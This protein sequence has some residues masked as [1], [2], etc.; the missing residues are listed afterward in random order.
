[1]KNGPLFPGLGVS[2][3]LCF[4]VCEIPCPWVCKSQSQLLSI[5]VN[6]HHILSRQETRGAKVEGLTGPPV[7]IVD[8][9]VL[10]SE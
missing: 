6:L 5:A 4:S 3:A 1:M 9:W 8:S 10:R 7:N 2:R